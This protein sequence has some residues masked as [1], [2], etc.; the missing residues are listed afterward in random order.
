M[1]KISEAASLAM[2]TMTLL[3]QDPEKVHTTHEIAKTLGVSEA[4]LSKVLQRLHKAGL[5]ASVRGAHGGFR[6]AMPGVEVTMLEVYEAIEGPF[7]GAPCLLG[8]PVCGADGCILGD[9]LERV[10]REVREY[11]VNTRLSQ[12]KLKPGRN[13]GQDERDR[14]D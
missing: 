14:Q 2:H 3:V 10:N 9:L 7:V 5:V 8:R 4:H 1:L 6:P 12:L 11:L 13:D